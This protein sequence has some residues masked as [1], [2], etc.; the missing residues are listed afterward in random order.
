MN[1]ILIHALCVLAAQGLTACRSWC[2]EHVSIVHCV[3]WPAM[4]QQSQEAPGSH[5]DVSVV[6][7]DE[8]LDKGECFSGSAL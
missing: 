7:T 6:C 2:M 4:H 3:S 8:Q 1:A 5:W